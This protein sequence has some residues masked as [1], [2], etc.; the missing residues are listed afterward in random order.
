VNDLVALRLL[1]ARIVR[2]LANRQRNR[3]LF[4]LE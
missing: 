2:S 1:H 4:R 3:D